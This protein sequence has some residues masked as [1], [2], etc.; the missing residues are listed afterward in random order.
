[1]SNIKFGINQEFI[2]LVE[3]EVT[4]ESSTSFEEKIILYSLI[5]SL[6]PE[7]IVETGTHRGKTTLYMAQAVIDNEKGL[8]HTLDPFEWGAVGNFRKF[9]EHEKV[10]K[11]YP[12]KGIDCPLESFDFIFID[13]FH[14][15]SEVEAEIKALIPK[16]KKGGVA[17]F[18]D[19]YPSD[20]NLP[21][22]PE[23]VTASIAKCGL[24][25]VQLNTQ[26][27]MRIYA[28]D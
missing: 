13:G 14:T 5:R 26:C 27:G 20:A 16:L 9:P 2:D 28:K 11:Y 10:I 3:K 4:Q 17:V 22:E 15:P 8:I 18:H 21:F 1:M 7:V 19:T 12:I 6:K 24:T 25:T 23:N